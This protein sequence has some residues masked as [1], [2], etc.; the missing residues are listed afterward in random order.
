MREI[1]LTQEMH[2]QHYYMGIVYSF[3]NLNLNDFIYAKRI[4]ILYPF[5]S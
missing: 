1:A 3:F 5:M 4:R 2:F